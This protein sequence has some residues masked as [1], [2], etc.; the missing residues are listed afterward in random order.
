MQPIKDTPA[1]P[2]HCRST[3]SLSTVSDSMPDTHS[4]T[5]VADARSEQGWLT[6]HIPEHSRRRSSAAFLSPRFVEV[7][8]PSS[9][10]TAAPSETATSDV[11][12]SFRRPYPPHPLPF[13]SASPPV[14]NQLEEELPTE[15]DQ[16]TGVLPPV[17]FSD[18]FGSQLDSIPSQECLSPS[19]PLTPV[20]LPATVVTEYT[21]AA[22][23]RATSPIATSSILCSPSGHSQ[24]DAALDAFFAFPE[25]QEVPPSVPVA[26]GSDEKSISDAIHHHDTIGQ[27][28]EASR[29]T[30]RNFRRNSSLSLAL[31][32]NSLPSSSIH[33]QQHRDSEAAFTLLRRYLVEN[34]RATLLRSGSLSN[35][36]SLV[37]P[38]QPSATSVR[39]PM[40]ASRFTR[41]IDSAMY[42]RL[43]CGRVSTA[44]QDSRGRRHRPYAVAAATTKAIPALN[45]GTSTHPAA[46][47]NTDDAFSHSLA[48]IGL[49]GMWDDPRAMDESPAHDIS[50]GEALDAWDAIEFRGIFSG[51]WTSVRRRVALGIFTNETG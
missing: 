26:A 23:P 3:E 46:E 41:T 35:L 5:S 42:H 12:S 39:L 45:S 43:S 9:R 1:G 16:T 37:S 20:T 28:L 44:S 36:H 7:S 50:S 38:V 6:V 31:P 11:G 22:V 24:S 17:T 4:W 8:P 29:Y 32:V 47:S 10:P 19:H 33:H 51:L 40:K 30:R 48:G 49:F 2:H 21:D 27:E 34:R 13:R 25:S 14:L 15:V 18:L